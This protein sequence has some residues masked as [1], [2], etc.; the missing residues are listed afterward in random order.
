M[1]G[2]ASPF[3]AAQL[4][5]AAA[6][7]VAAGSAPSWWGSDLEAL[8]TSGSVPAPNFQTQKAQ[9]GAATA[10]TA[11]A[12]WLA[13]LQGQGQTQSG[14]WVVAN[15]PQGRQIYVNTATGQTSATAPG[16][17]P[18]P[19]SSTPTVGDVSKYLQSLVAKGSGSA[20]PNAYQLTAKA[21]GSAN[22]AWMSGLNELSLGSGS[23][24]SYGVGSP[25]PA[26]QVTY[27]ESGSAYNGSNLGSAI[28]INK[29]AAKNIRRSDDLNEITYSS[30]INAE[31]KSAGPITTLLDLT[32][33]DIQEDD[34][35]PLRSEITWFTRDQDRR[36]LAFSPV[37]QE[38][39]LR[40]P[41]A[42]G[43]RFAFD[44][45]SIM[46]GDLLLGTA[47]Q[48]R[49]DHWLD[50]QT[51]N[52]Y[53]A[54]KLTYEDRAEAWEYANSLGTAIIQQAELEIDGKTI[55]TI[56]GDFIQTFSA[57][58]PEYNT[59][60]GVAYDHLGQASMT[61]LKDP[62]RTPSIFPVENGNLNC[63]LPFFFMRSRLKEA[64]PMI[65]IREGYVKIYITLRPFDQ[66]VRQMRGFRDTCTS[67]PPPTATAFTFRVCNWSYDIAAGRGVWDIPPKA[68]FIYTVAGVR[69]NWSYS[70][71]TERGSWSVP[72]EF[73]FTVAAQY[74]WTAATRTW[75]P[76]PPPYD[77]AY[78]DPTN[79]SRYYYWDQIPQ[80]WRNGFPPMNF[81][82]GDNTWTSAVGDWSTAA[83]AFKAVQLLTYGAIVNGTYRSKML[84]DPFEILHRVVQ[85]FYF[86]EPLKYSIGK[87]Q[88]AIRIQLPLEA[89][90]P[91]EEII[92]FVRRKGTSINNEWTNFTG[93][94]ES[95]WNPRAA[96]KPLLENA[97]IQV[98]G[99]VLCDADEQFYR[100]G[101]ASAHRGGF[102]AYSRFIYGYSFAKTPGEHQPS[103]SM[104]ASRLNALRL[105]LD[106]VPP[107]GVL[108]A[109]WE[110]KVFCIGMNWMRFENGLANPMFED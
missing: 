35:F 48:I 30:S 9:Q 110:V 77:I 32:N 71:E 72:P 54:G 55:E 86:D 58:F 84:R 29:D 74:S 91:I 51:Q 104:N 8:N 100:E 73:S 14:S 93:V 38:T 24:G 10:A 59:Q 44:L 34:L 3:T 95:E 43:Q 20:A 65:A 16:Q 64:L 50:P 96:Q 63:I 103:G 42:F 52:M 56:D 53:M 109:T 101:I 106:V 97:I 15:D 94:L 2:P 37:I 69:Y 41:A 11:N 7:Y 36:L 12:K 75:S 105:I 33:R 26:P 83:P 5:A 78:Q 66:C 19:T 67:V 1:S 31:P 4:Q 89:N 28:P 46:V 27:K 92:W 90:H 87:R 23:L 57:L 62:A 80:A 22:T 47:L 21:A 102:A 81:I 107:G 88:D 70:A 61:R 76:G 39:A 13:G 45:G 98:N 25:R 68:S 49:L 60:F 108:D 6:A 99:T 17:G 18:A 85:T 79:R 40:G 82:Y